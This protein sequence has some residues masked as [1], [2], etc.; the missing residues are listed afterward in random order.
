MII[1]AGAAADP[2]DDA[3]I[4]TPVKAAICLA[5]LDT[6][7]KPPAFPAGNALKVALSSLLIL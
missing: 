7:L 5:H 1:P 2:D 3:T 4:A 6:C